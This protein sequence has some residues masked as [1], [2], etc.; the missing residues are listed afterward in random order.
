SHQPARLSL[1]LGPRPAEI[2]PD[3]RLGAGSSFGA[4]Q[5]HAVPPKPAYAA[6]HGTILGERAVA[7][8]RHEFADQPGDVIEAM[9]PLGMARYQHLL[10]RIEP[11]IALAQQPVR[12]GFEPRDLLGDV[13][14]AVGRQVAQL[15]DLA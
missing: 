5:H 9:R 3:P 4:G 13:E 1:T 8:E 12:L 11:R 10:P 7:G 14:P 6:D 2:A 15:F